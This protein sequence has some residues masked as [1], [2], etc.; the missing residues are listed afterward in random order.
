MSF[1][2]PERDAGRRFRKAAQARLASSFDDDPP[3][4]TVPD[5]IGQFRH[6]CPA[7]GGV[8]TALELKEN[9][10]YSPACVDLD[11]PAGRFGFIF[12]EGR[13]RHCAATAR[14][15]PGRLVDGWTRPPTAGR[16]ARS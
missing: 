16:V 8:S 1:T 15:R 9:Y 6:P 2:D 13:C 11:V 3:D 14:S 4:F 12:R 10:T 5:V 7:R